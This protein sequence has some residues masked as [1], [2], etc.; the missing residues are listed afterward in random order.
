MAIPLEDSLFYPESDGEPMAET[1][2]HLLEMIY[3]IEA[4]RQRFAATADVYV[5]G[6]LFLYYEEG[7]PEAVVAPD[8][9]VVKGVP[10]LPPRRKYLLWEEGVAPCFVLEITSDSTRR[11]DMFEKKA[12]YEKLGVQEYLL[13]DP[14]GDYLTP[15]LQGFHLVRGRYRP[16]RPQRNGALTSAALG[17]AVQAEG[18]CL[19]LVNS[20][21]GQPLLRREEE[22]ALRLRAESLAQAEAAR[23]D[24]EAARADREAARAKREAAKAKGEATKAKLEA[25]RA[26][27]EA[28][29]RRFA[30]ER[31]R[32]LE[33]ELARLTPRSR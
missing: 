4:L 33:A 20:V 3:A 18:T 21:T 25:A 32:A 31:V 2:I 15:P 30:E 5:G 26:D 28:E 9:F 10:K 19:R 14:L 13:F 6:D 16:L 27:R 17:L 12:V 7:H 8:A 22:V 24:R 11:R 1:E 23:A 29:A